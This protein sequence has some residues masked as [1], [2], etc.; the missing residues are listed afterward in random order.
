MDTAKEALMSNL[1]KWI[2]TTGIV[3]LTAAVSVQALAQPAIEFED[4]TEAVGLHEHLARWELGHGGAVGDVTG[5]GRPDLYIG[6][7]A[8]RPVYEDPNAPIPNMLFLNRPE[9]FTLS[10]DESV[11]FDYRGQP[12]NERARLAMALF[13]DLNNNGKLDLLAGNHGGGPASRLFE[14]RWPDGFRNV[15]P[16]EGGWPQSF[17]MRNATA[18]DLD[19]DGLLDLILLDG[20]Y[21][22]TDQRVIALRNLGN[23]QFEDVS[24]QYG[25]TGRARALGSGVGD[26]NNDGRLD[27]FVAHSNRLFVSQPDGTYQEYRPGFF[28]MPRDASGDWPC[29][30]HLADLTGNGLLDLVVSMHGTPGELYLYVNRGIDEQ[31]MPMFEDV[32]EQAGLRVM[33]PRRTAQFALVDLDNNGRRDILMGMVQRDEQGRMK[34]VVL[35]NRGVRDGIP[36]FELPDMESIAGYYATA[37]VADFDRDGRIDIFMATWSLRVPNALFRNVTKA[38]NYLLVSVRGEGPRLNRMGIGATVRVYAAGHLGQSEHL[39]SRGD[40]AIGNGYSSGD[41]AIAHFGLA[42]HQHCD[43]HIT[44]QG[45]DVRLTNVPVNQHLTVPVGR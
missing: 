23:F 32:T 8:D 39:L 4:I 33:F 42:D 26:V 2:A 24:E 31:G 34:P 45:H 12:R 29:A 41:E 6:A 38:G 44:W 37:P 17:H 16:T 27:I 22:G 19:Q 15:T 35:R 28:R 21:G 3:A 36:Q 5:N 20:R 1:G 14:N 43:L 13:V 25:F 30:A 7:F 11:R 18:I 10:P 40:I 9:G